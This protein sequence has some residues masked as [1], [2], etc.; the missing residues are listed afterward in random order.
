MCTAH[1]GVVELLQTGKL[2]SR[3]WDWRMGANFRWGMVS[4]SA[5]LVPCQHAVTV[6][7]SQ[8]HRMTG[9][10]AAAGMVALSN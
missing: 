4:N 9:A 6:S 3:H 7:R 5:G 2:S 8:G 1:A 10:P